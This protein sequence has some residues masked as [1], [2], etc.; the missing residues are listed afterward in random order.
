MS[1]L[2]KSA[3]IVMSEIILGNAGVC[4]KGPGKRQFI[5]SLG[6][7]TQPTTHTHTHTHTHTDGHAVSLW[8]VASLQGWP[9]LMGEGARGPGLEQN[10]PG[11]IWCHHI[12]ELGSSFSG[13][14]TLPVSGSTMWDWLHWWLRQ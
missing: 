13:A 2:E 1:W 12:Q 10:L 9:H 7:D 11:I 4:C 6:S 3:G 14:Q 5:T 8:S